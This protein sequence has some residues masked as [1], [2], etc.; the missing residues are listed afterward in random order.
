VLVAPKTEFRQAC[1]IQTEQLGSAHIVS[2]ADFIFQPAN[3]S[4]P[5]SRR[6]GCEEMTLRHASP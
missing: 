5:E 3:A 6:G 2:K 1:N 4:H